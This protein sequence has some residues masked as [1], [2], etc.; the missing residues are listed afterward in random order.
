MA[1]LDGSSWHGKLYSGGWR[2]GAG[3]TMPVVSPSTG[4]E[5]ATIGR[6]DA[7][8]VA[9]AAAGPPRRRARGPR[10]RTTS[11]R[12]CCAAPATCGTRTPRRSP[13]G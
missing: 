8:D 6:A 13:A 9:A 2:D 3:G 10:R 11:E 4:E 1:L 12:P 5:L 7:A